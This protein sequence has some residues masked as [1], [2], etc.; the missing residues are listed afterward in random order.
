MYKIRY[1][2]IVLSIVN[3]FVDS[4]RIFDQNSY[5]TLEAI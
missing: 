5:S 2:V 3:F 1:V 4:I